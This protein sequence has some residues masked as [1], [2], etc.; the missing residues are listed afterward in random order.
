M[1]KFSQE[2]SFYPIIWIQATINWYDASIHVSR[3][4]HALLYCTFDYKYQDQRYLLMT[5]YQEKY[6]DLLVKLMHN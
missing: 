1:S 2:R 6:Y 5:P 3:I 4:P